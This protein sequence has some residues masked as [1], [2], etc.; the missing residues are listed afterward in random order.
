[1]T[2]KINTSSIPG[3]N[4]KEGTK[5]Y[6]QDAQCTALTYNSGIDI[7]VMLFCPTIHLPG[8]QRVIFMV[9]AS[10]NNLHG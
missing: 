5:R 3:K 4:A 1:M 6:I 2:A 7:R 8:L 9:S 10:I